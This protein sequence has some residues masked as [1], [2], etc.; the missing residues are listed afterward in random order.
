MF[1]V[2]GFQHNPEN[3]VC[4]IA[5]FACPLVVD[6]NDISS[7]VCQNCRNAFQLSGFVFQLDGESIT[8]TRFQQATLDNSG[9]NCHVNITAG[10]QTNDIFPLNIGNLIEHYR[11]HWDSSCTFCNEFMLFNQCQN[12]RGNFIICH[13]H[14]TINIFFRDCKSVFSCFFH[15]DTVRNGGNLIK[16]NNF[17]L[18]KGFRHRRRTACLYPIDTDF[19]VQ[20]FQCKRYTRNQTATT[21]RHNNNVNVSQLLADFQ[22]DC[23]LTCNNVLV[24]KRMNESIAFFVTEFQCLCIGIIINPR[25]KA[26]FRTIALCSFH[27]RNRRTIRQTN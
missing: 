5:V 20:A 26:N 18:F 14:N 23:P 1:I 16:T 11:S 8:A 22:T 15:F 6:R 27:F 12:C 3:T 17:V 10:H 7:E 24:I 19:R 2:S 25:N 13:S 4:N 9:K 21:D